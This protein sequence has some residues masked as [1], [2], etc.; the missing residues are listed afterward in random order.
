MEATHC[1]LSVSWVKPCLTHGRLYI[2][3][4]LFFLTTAPR[5]KLARPPVFFLVGYVFSFSVNVRFLLLVLLCSRQY[6]RPR[7]SV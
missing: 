4:S 6:F 2:F 7:C 5:L 1:I 3:L